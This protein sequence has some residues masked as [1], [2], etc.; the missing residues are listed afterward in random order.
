MEPRSH[1]PSTI[2]IEYKIIIPVLR[3]HYSTTNQPRLTSVH[4]PTTAITRHTSMFV[5]LHSYASVFAVVVERGRVVIVVVDARTSLNPTRVIFL[6][7]LPNAFLIGA[8]LPLFSSC[9]HRVWGA[10]GNLCTLVPFCQIK[11]SS[12][13]GDTMAPSRLIRRWQIPYL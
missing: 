4:S 1:R 11:Y 9:E 3:R 6:T 2:I 7:R 12:A 8:I 10:H 5:V 13:I